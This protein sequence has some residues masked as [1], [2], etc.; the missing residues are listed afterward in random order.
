MYNFKYFISFLFLYNIF[1]INCQ[2]NWDRWGDYI[3]HKHKKIFYP[4]NLNDVKAIINKAIKKNYNI[5]AVGSLHSWRSI[6]NTNGYIINTDKLNKI[7]YIDKQN[8]R[9]KVE[10]GIKLKNLFKILADNNLALSNQG[11]IAE[12]SIAGAIST[13]THGTGHTGCLSDFVIELEILDGLGNLHKVSK[14]SNSDWLSYL[15]VNLGALGFIYSVTLECQDLFLLNH[16]REIS[17]WDD[18]LENYDKYFSE[19]DYYMFMG[20]PRYDIVL[21]FFWNKLGNKNSFVKRSYFRDIPEYTVTNNYLSR[22]AIKSISYMPLIGNR[23]IQVWLYSMQKSLHSQYSYL[24]LS[25]IINPVSVDY[26]IEAE[27]AIEIKDFAKVMQ[28]I[29]D[30]YI[31]YENENNLSLAAVYT[32]RFSPG[33]D[34]SNLS[35]AYKRDTAYITINI[36]NYFDNYMDFFRKLDIIFERYLA[37]PHWGKFHFLNKDKVSLLY[38]QENIE[39]FNLLRDKLD[40]NKIFANDYIKK[41]FG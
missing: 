31:E 17:D 28:E 19:N 26:Y 11:F 7:L 1:D 29:R 2:I 4:E 33:F 40:P 16:K 20:H 27:Y 8:K 13:G 21:N 38:G 3:H 39:K 25:P 37:R 18:A 34:L 41:C 15:R 36:L 6:V 35:L 30:F 9:V 24:S 12:Q 32:C 10:C 5:R 23:L 14:E 22:A